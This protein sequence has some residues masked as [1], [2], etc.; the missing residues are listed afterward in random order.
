MPHQLVMGTP[1]KSP[2]D[3][4]LLGPRLG[5]E[6]VFR[7]YGARVE[8]AVRNTG[9]AFDV[10]NSWGEYG[11]QID[12][13]LDEDK[14]NLAGVTNMDVALSL[15]AYYSGHP[16]TK[17]REEDRQIPIKLRLPPSQRKSLD[18]I[19][20]VYV[21][22]LMG[23]LPLESVTEISRSWQPAKLQ[24]YQ[25]ERCFSVRDASGGRSSVQRDHRSGAA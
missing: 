12:V 20:A 10:H 24:R 23:K 15:N 6:R 4:R 1:V 25:R 19:D 18:E 11:R 8:E 9:I 2:V 14:A 16:L 17:F 13:R 7:K 21:N 5:N 22:S 3:I